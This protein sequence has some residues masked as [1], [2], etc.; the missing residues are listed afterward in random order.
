[1]PCT[2]PDI[3]TIKKNYTVVEAV[4]D[5]RG[6]WPNQLGNGWFTDSR[7]LVDD[8]IDMVV[9]NVPRNMPKSQSGSE[10]A[11]VLLELGALMKERDFGDYINDYAMMV[12]GKF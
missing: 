11:E 3:F 10:V 6:K 7:F 1:M 8:L 4:H 12:A 2:T 9:D 5:I